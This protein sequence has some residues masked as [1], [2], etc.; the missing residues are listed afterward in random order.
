MHT[1]THPYLFN[2]IIFIFNELCH[3]L[4]HKEMLAIIKSIYY[5]LSP[6]WELQFY[7]LNRGCLHMSGYDKS[8][9]W[10]L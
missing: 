9:M 6:L 8:V 1:H 10:M 3:I 5:K 7:Y 2:C 4:I